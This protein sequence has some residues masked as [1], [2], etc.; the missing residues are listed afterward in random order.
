M[1]NINTTVST[2]YIENIKQENR[3]ND[4]IKKFIFKSNKMIR[5]DNNNIIGENYIMEKSEYQK[6]F[7]ELYDVDQDKMVRLS[8]SIEFVIS[9]D[10]DGFYYSNEEYN[11]YVYGKTQNDAENNLLCE[12]KFQYHSYVFEN[13]CDL[14][15]NAQ[16]LK[17]KLLS[18][19]EQN[20]KN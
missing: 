10:E 4:F 12:L 3:L 2:P 8:K 13:D 16:K 1:I 20:A 11:V 15:T 5:N 19:F 9:S 18:L 14:D 7:I 17:Y 6:S